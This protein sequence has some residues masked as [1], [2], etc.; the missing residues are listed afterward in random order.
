MY[1]YIYIYILYKCIYILCIYIYI[2]TM[3]RSDIGTPAT[4]EMGGVTSWEQP[5][6]RHR[7]VELL[8]SRKLTETN[9]DDFM[10]NPSLCF[11]G[12]S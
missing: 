2:L 4:M 11:V 5:K 12:F 1:V 9:Y 6:H 3:N 10:G 7:W 8:E